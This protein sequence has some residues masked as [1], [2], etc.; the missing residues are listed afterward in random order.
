MEFF[1]GKSTVRPGPTTVSIQTTFSSS[2]TSSEY[3]TKADAGSQDSQGLQAKMPRIATLNDTG[4]KPSPE[5]EAELKRRN[6]LYIGGT[7]GRG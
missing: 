5:E 6:E 2:V 1:V 4:K 7:D 3:G